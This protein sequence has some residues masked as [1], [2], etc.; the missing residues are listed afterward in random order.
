MQSVGLI[1]QLA[2]GFILVFDEPGRKL[3]A[4]EDQA[5]AKHQPDEIFEKGII[6]PLLLPREARVR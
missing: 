4:I 5:N 2:A 1:H 6:V 3:A